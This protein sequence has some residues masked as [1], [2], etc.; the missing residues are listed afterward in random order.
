MRPTEADALIAG[1]GLFDAAFYV[2]QS[3]AIEDSGLD[4]IRHYIVYGAAEG[5]DPHPLFSTSFY[6]NSNPDVAAAGMNP[7][8]HYLLAGAAEGRDPHPWFDTSFYCEANP[9][10]VQAGMNPLA[11][12]VQ[13]GAMESRDPHPLFDNSFYFEQ[14]PHVRALGVNPLVHFLAAGPTAEFDPLSPAPA[15]ADTGICI[16]TPDLVGPVKN[17]GIG[18]A[19][20]HFARVLV[21]AGHTVSVVF[22]LDLTECQRAHWRNAYARMGISFIALPDLPPVTRLVHGSTWFFERSWRVFEYLRR[23][24]F[25]VVHFQDWHAN[26]FWSIKAKRVGPAFEKTTLTVMMHSCTKW[27]NEGMQEFGANPLETAKLVWA[28]TYCMEGCDYL[29]SPSRYM[30]E[31][32]AANHVRTPPQSRLTPY[33]WADRTSADSGDAA[34]AVRRPVDNDHLIFFG[35]LE[36]RKGLHIFADALRRLQRAGGEALPRTISFL[37]KH[38]SVLGRSSADFLEQLRR[39]LQIEDI[40]IIDHFDY[41]QALA[42]IRQAGGLVVLP[43][44]L[45]N[46][47]LTVI[48][49][50]QSGIPFIAAAVGGIPE[51]VDPRVIFDPNPISLAERLGTRQTI[52]HTQV[53]HKYPGDNAART[54][55]DLHGM[56]LSADTAGGTIAAGRSDTPPPR[57]SV[58]IPFS[59]HQQYLQ[60]LVA[61]FARQRYGAFEVVFVNDGSS[62][63][64]SREFD[65]VA[66]L[67]HDRRFH[68]HTTPG[69]GPGAARNVAVG[70]ASGELLMF[71]DADNLPKG[72]DFIGTMVCAIQRSNVDCVTSAYDTVGADRRAVSERDV[73]ATYR[74]IGPCIEAA[75]FE[76]VLGDATLIITRDAFTGCGG[77]PTHG[78]MSS[79]EGDGVR[80]SGQQRTWEDHEF[81]LNLCFK[82]RTLETFPEATFFCRQRPRDGNHR[83][84][85]Y[86]NYQSLFA[87]LQRAP[88]ESLVRII[89]AVTG[90]MLIARSGDAPTDL[91]SQ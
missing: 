19:S 17:G 44:I 61:A 33:V 65:R 67:C 49:C 46:Y 22:T 8:A 62:D 84:N 5:L 10:V 36:T 14:K 13:Y 63:E 74:P 86:R 60:E 32:A 18:T 50:V 45:D 4:P 34:P 66:M 41:T 78:Q 2:T 69:Q 53:V 11:H 35:R 64:A 3:R 40:R 79:V 39:D 48:E 9:D 85:D 15:P 72:P 87:Q 54:W 80:P 27:L 91:V 59:N 21:E 25:S 7:L 73:M 12:Y 28:E 56:L 71:F 24:R 47:P 23:A 83:A 68:F 89:A 76:N 16:V 29:L 55:L 30:L 57:V 81:L 42:Y 38:A 52:D 88:S 70:Y 90:P 20:F 1:S 58:C 75:F 26:G 77:F 31:W 51:M 82:G 6:Q 43:S 37:G